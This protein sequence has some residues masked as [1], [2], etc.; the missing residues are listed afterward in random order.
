MANR[1]ALVGCGFLAALLL[2]LPAQSAASQPDRGPRGTD[3]GISIIDG[4][5]TSIRDWPWQIALAWSRQAEPGKA[6]SG[7]F[8]CGGSV[9]APRL[10]ITAGHCVADLNLKQVRSLEVISGRTQIN[11]NRGQVARVNGISMPRNASGKR[12]YSVLYGA[13]NWDVALLT[14]ASPLAAEPIK[15]AG[16]DEA[17][18][19]APGQVAWTT[20][21]GV[22]RPYASRIPFN[23]QAAR[24]VMLASSLCRQVDGVAFSAFTMNC[25]GG[26]GGN[27]STCSGD[28]GGP[29]VVKTSEGYRLAGLTSY[30]DEAC[31][32]F[33]PSV[34]TRVS[35]DRIRPW[36]ADTAMALTGVDVV[37]SGGTAA[38]QPAWCRIPTV[39]G[40]LPARARRALERSNCRLGKV[41]IDPWAGGNRGRIV[42]ASRFPGWLAS[43]GFRLDVWTSPRSGIK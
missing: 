17:A 1:A 7:R 14:L 18:S 38:P 25:V 39:V 9:L 36:V 20:G 12:R 34:F 43:P 15:L 29:L 10:V 40:L 13:A 30:G 37:G 2:A 8:F 24:Q 11:S 28:S 19:W 21:W 32:G 5:R 6:T 41:R 16:P 4:K 35:G 33:V 3:A 23:L 31:R 42:D 26:P 22:S 27:A